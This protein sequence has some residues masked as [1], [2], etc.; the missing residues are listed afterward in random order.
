MTQGLDSETHPV[1]HLLGLTVPDVDCQLVQ[2]LRV[3]Q[4]A[5]CQDLGYLWA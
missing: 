4:L 5:D 2:F 1:I 3:G